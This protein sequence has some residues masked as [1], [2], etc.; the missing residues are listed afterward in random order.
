[1]RAYS[2]FDDISFEATQILKA[3]GIDLVIHPQGLERPKGDALKRIIAD[4][5]IIIIGTSQ[6]VDSNMFEGLNSNKI[7]ATLSIGVDHIKVPEEKKAFIRIVNCPISN[8]TSVVEHSFGM[9]LSLEKQFSDAKRASSSGLNKSYMKEKPQDIFGK[10]IGI[11]GTG[12][13]GLTMIRYAKVFGL[14]IVCFSN[15]SLE[16]KKEIGERFVGIDELLSLSDIVFV[17]LPFLESTSNLIDKRKID[18]IKQ[19]GMLISI[20]HSGVVDAKAAIERAHKCGTFKVGLDVDSSDVFPDYKG[21]EQN[22]IITPHIAGGT[23]Q[24]R[25]RM[26]VELC[27][28]IVRILG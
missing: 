28:N 17:S 16:R 11:I 3:A 8:R 20:S 26:F 7:I 5:D 14:N 19:D 12:G 4:Y 13:I 18:L 10:T 1:M 24:A 21:N 6:K 25:K 23:I 22:I 2:I 15:D 9:I 27:T